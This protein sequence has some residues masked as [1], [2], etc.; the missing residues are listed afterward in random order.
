M[1]KALAV[2]RVNKLRFDVQH[3][4]RFSLPS[5]SLTSFLWQGPTRWQGFARTVR[6]SRSFAPV[7]LQTFLAEKFHLWT[8]RRFGIVTVFGCNTDNGRGNRKTIGSQTR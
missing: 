1:E 3:F 5:L 6:G 8:N 2:L 7:V 4:P